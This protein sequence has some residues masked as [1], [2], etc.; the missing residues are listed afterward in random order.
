MS[1]SL[2]GSAVI[3]DVTMITT[4]LD[5]AQA[6]TRHELGRLADD[7]TG[8]VSMAPAFAPPRVPPLFPLAAYLVMVRG[9]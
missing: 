1:G 5:E 3:T 6:L 8:L 2:L 7:G 4:V 9:E